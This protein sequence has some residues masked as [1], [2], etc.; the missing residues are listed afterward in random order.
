LVAIRASCRRSPHGRSFSA[1]CGT[2]GAGWKTSLGTAI[3]S[4]PSTLRFYTQ[5]AGWAAARGMLRPI[6]LLVDG[7]AV[8]AE[9]VLTDGR[10]TYVKGG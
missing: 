6:F 10:A 9:F 2:V 7:R 4:E 5:V 1:W 3:G 8:A